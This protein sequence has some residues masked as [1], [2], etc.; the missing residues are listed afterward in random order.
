MG[1][2]DSGLGCNS[3]CQIM[4]QLQLYSSLVQLQLYPQKLRSKSIHPM[5]I[6]WQYG[7]YN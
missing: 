1:K 4:V 2:R 3:I 6:N 7:V 5:K